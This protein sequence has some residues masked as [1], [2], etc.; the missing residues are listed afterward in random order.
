MSHEEDRALERLL[1][2]LDT[3]EAVDD[4]VVLE[5]GDDR[6]LREYRELLALLPFALDP[7]TP[8]AECREGLLAKIAAAARSDAPAPEIVPAPTPTDPLP[9]PA[10]ARQRASRALQLIAATLAS[11]VVGLGLFSGW[12][13]S[14]YR[15]QGERIEAIQVT[16]LEGRAREGDLQ[17]SL[18]EIERLRA[19]VTRTSGRVCKLRPYGDSPAQPVARAAVYFD[20]EAQEYFLAASDLTP[21]TDGYSYRLWFMVNDRAVPGR[22]FNVSAGKPVALGSAGM[23]AG[24]TAMMVTYQRLDS[25]EP[26]GERIL[27]G[28]ESHEM[29]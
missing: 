2:E 15:D 29:L 19:L 23:P 7:V 8:T 27:Y 3:P 21:C 18:G 24:T 16:M 13:Y 9:F 17:A 6:L 5:S 1:E 11:A 22:S 10:P 28:D 4:D 12:L 25:V 14:Q 20:M 26:D